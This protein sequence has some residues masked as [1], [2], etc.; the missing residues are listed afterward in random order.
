MNSDVDWFIGYQTELRISNTARYT[1]NFM[2]QLTRFVSDANTKLLI[3]SNWNGGLGQDSSGLGN[4][5]TPTNLVATDQVLDSPTN[6]FCT[7]NPLIR[8]AGA[9]AYSEGNLQAHPTAAWDAIAGTIG[10]GS[11]KWYW[12]Q[13]TVTQ[14]YSTLGIVGDNASGWFDTTTNPQTGTGFILYAYNGNKEIDNVTTAYGASFTSDDIIGVALNMDDSEVT[15]YKN[16]AT[17][18]AIAFSGTIA[19]A[20]LVMPGV[21]LVGGS[22]NPLNEYNF[23]AGQDSSFA[24]NFTAQGNQDENDIGDFYYTPP[25][26]YL[27]L[28]TS[29]LSDPSIKKPG[30]NFDVQIWTGT[31]AAKV[32]TTG[33][34]TDFV[35]GKNRNGTSSHCLMDI[36]RGTSST[37]KSNSNAAVE[38]AS[39]VITSFDS[40][41]YTLGDSATGP[42]L[43]QNGSDT[44]V[45]WAWKAGGASTVTNNDGS[46]ESEVSAN[47]TAGFSIFTYTGTGAAATVGH[48]LSSK[49]DMI[50]FK[51]RNTTS[52][53]PVYYERTDAGALGFPLLESDA[54]KIDSSFTWNSTVFTFASAS[55]YSNTSLTN[56][57][58]YAFQSIEGY[59][60]VGTYTGNGNADGTFVYLGFRPAFTLVKRV[61]VTE[62]WWL[63]DDVRDLYNMQSKLLYAD[64]NNAE[65]TEGNKDYVSNG[66][67]MRLN[68]ANWNAD[69]GTY[70]YLRM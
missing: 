12:E 62:N 29:N 4:N 15:F 9:V 26:G 20:K 67:K 8:P 57:I 22:P 56:Y 40:T 64:L 60:K 45:G 55:G 69:G 28:C 24:G 61:D 39:D 6:N 41:G 19:N 23:N 21:N 25:A 30:T 66:M 58:A 44:F 68:N 14:Y 3:H 18:G 11:G 16:N 59:S 50:I 34:Q 65:A 52:S 47:T 48:G 38:S 33:F 53:W 31:A 13:V 7:L 1:A 46:I 54:I 42:N 32:I 27:A 37:L 43:N 36:V 35:W 10:V 63:E 2:P 17:Q 70:L 49:P 5:F 51:G